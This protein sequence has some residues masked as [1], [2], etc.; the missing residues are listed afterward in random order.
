MTDST[1][2]SGVFA[3][4]IL[5]AEAEQKIIESQV[6]KKCQLL[7]GGNDVNVAD[8]CVPGRIFPFPTVGCA[9]TRMLA[10]TNCFQYVMDLSK[11]EECLGLRL[12]AALET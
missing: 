2:A 4:A 12:Q 7:M 3:S 5:Q 11:A 10:R 8:S 9:C 6:L 1:N